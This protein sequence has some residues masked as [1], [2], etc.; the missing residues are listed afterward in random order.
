MRARTV[1]FVIARPVRLQAVAALLLALAAT[2]V[3]RAHDLLPPPFRGG[4]GTT[5]QA[6]EFNNAGL[7]APDGECPANNPFGAPSAS[8]QGN[9]WLNFFPANPPNLQGIQCLPLG[10]SLHFDIPNMAD[11]VLIKTVWVQV[12]FHPHAGSDIAVTVTDP[13]GNAAVLAGAQDLPVPKHPAWI[14]RTLAFCFTDCP[15]DVDVDVLALIDHVDIDQV[16]IDTS[17]ATDCLP[18]AAPMLPDDYDGDGIADDQDN[19]PGVANPN[20]ADCDCDGFGN[21][22]DLWGICV[23]GTP[24]ENEACGLDL[25]GGC[26][27][28][29]TVFEAIACGDTVCGT[30]WADGGLRDTDWYELNLP[31]ID[32]DG[33]AKVRVEICSALPVVGVIFDDDCTNLV[34]LAQTEANPDLV[35][36]VTACLPAPATYYIFVA[37][38]TLGGGIFN[39]FPCGTANEYSLDVDCFEPCGTG[40]TCNCPYDLDDS[41]TVSIVDLL[42]MLAA[43]GPNP[44]HPADLNCDGFVNVLD[45]LALL[46]GW[47]ACP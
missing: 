23:P 25:N 33:L 14:H 26:N 7:G 9:Q 47:G 19:A 15:P 3:S 12:V 22:S 32:G 40:G 44:G 4:P 18:P 2:P 1:R 21:V 27:S 41:G 30:A 39:G 10:A 46:S 11:P 43:W 24:P 17:C 6:W 16:I 28:N 13:I 38:G 29:P 8:G 42:I 45:F 36:C 5:F 37:P 31:D 20:Q 34:A 35:G